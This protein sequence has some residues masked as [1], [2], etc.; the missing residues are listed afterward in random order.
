VAIQVNRQI[1]E[2][3]NAIMTAGSLS[4]AQMWAETIYGSLAFMQGYF[5]I[6]GQFP[7]EQKS[8]EASTE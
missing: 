1:Y 6:P 4:E 3:V 5:G 7:R 8:T 2:K